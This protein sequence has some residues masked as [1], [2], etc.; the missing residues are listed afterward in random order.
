MNRP[1]IL[2]LAA[3]AAV[4]S[5]VCAQKA[6]TRAHLTVADMLIASST[7]AQ[8]SLRSDIARWMA[9]QT[10]DAV[11]STS[12]WLGSAFSSKQFLDVYRQ[13]LTS[14]KEIGNPGESACPAAAAL[15]NS[16]LHRFDG[17]Y[18]LQ[19]VLTV[20][21]NY[22]KRPEPEEEARCK[23]WEDLYDKL[24]K[25]YRPLLEQRETAREEQLLRLNAAR[26]EV[27]VLPNGVQFEYEPG[28]AGIREI[29]RG[30]SETGIAFYSRITNDTSFDRLPESVKQM[31]DRLPKAASWTFYI[32]VSA[33]QAVKDSLLQQEQKLKE[34]RQAKLQKLIPERIKSYPRENVK[35]KAAP[36]SRRPLLKLKVWKDDPQ[37]PLKVLPDVTENV[38]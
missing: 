17:D 20:L 26:P 28:E 3:W 11:R 7:S 36:S 31:A 10:E 13:I 12:A 37:H 29:T 21:E 24:Q 23:E 1:I 2:A 35:E 32:P 5:S 9:M 30:T 4:T 33:E 34:Q 15:A 18:D 19:E 38:I 27:T 8:K 22:L 25:T 16:H 14:G 6:G